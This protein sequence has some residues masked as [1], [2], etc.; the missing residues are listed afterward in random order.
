MEAD[1]PGMSAARLAEILGHAAPFVLLGT[2]I[3]AGYFAML[4]LNVERYLSGRS[5]GP[6]IRL[7]IGRLL[8]AGIGFT[9]IAPAGAVPLLSSLIGFLLARAVALRWK[10]A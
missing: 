2:L 7:H 6:A 4:G 10:R 1:E 8:L 5:L 3:G 9:L